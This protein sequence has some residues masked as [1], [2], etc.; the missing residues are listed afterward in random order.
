VH[1]FALKGLFDEL[2]AIFDFFKAGALLQQTGKASQQTRDQQQIYHLI[3]DQTY[4][5]RSPLS[6]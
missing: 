3:L 2:A 6:W 4:S 1:V 5:H